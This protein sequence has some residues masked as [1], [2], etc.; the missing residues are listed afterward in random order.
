MNA[1]R[2][3]WH[4]SLVI[5]LIWIFVLMWAE[6]LPFIVHHMSLAQHIGSHISLWEFVSIIFVSG[7]IFYLKW[8]PQ[9]GLKGIQTGKVEDFFALKYWNIHLLWPP[10]LFLLIM[11][12]L[13]LYKGLPPNPML[14]TIIINTMMIGI[15][16]ELMFRGIL[17]YGASSSFGTWRA[18][19]I[20]AIIF[21]SIHILNG[22]I[23][24]DFISSTVQAFSAF[25][26]GF[27]IAALRIRLDTIITGIIIHWVWDCLDFLLVPQKLVPFK[28][29][30]LLFLLPFS[31]LFF[32][33]G[34]RLL[35]NGSVA[36]N[37]SILQNR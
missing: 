7:T 3:P 31:L 30:G 2:N 8:W 10:A 37:Q 14:I 36:K 34:F 4:I 23:T 25:V 13:V 24:G 17:L 1:L 22:F 9:V 27:W 12:L 29:S 5:L 11:L 15:F 20:T 6:S 26:F 18:V 19:W 33:Y 28:P 32:Y 21:G 16:E 35:K